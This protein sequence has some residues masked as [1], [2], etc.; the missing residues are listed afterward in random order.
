MKH[1]TVDLELRELE[2]S[3]FRQIT[4]LEVNDNQKKCVAPNLYSI[5]QA[6]F[7]KDAWFRGIYVNDKPVGF[8]MLE[9]NHKK[10]EYYLWRFM[11]DKNQQGKGYGKIALDHI[12]EY[13]KQFP[14]ATKLESSVV[15]GDDSPLKF[16]LN[17]GFK[18]TEKW[19][20]DEKVIVLD[21]V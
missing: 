3:T 19:D 4:K 7:N 21:L 15:M 11:I 2:D 13:L 14:K 12:V 18:E 17:Y 8:V 6:Y 20:D 10:P 16:Y 5:A 9:L 1:E